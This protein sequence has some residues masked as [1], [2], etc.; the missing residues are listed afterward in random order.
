M[1][2]L[3]QDSL[4]T[5]A[6]RWS[7]RRAALL[8]RHP[9]LPF[10]L[11]FVVYM[12]VGSLEMGQPTR[13]HPKT[14]NFLGIRHEHYPIVYTT[15]IVLTIAAMAFVWP[16]GTRQTAPPGAGAL[17]FPFRVSPLAIVVG[18][19]GVVLWVW[20]CS[21]QLERKLLEPIGL[22]KLLGLGDRPAYNPL[23]QLAD[24]PTWAY[25]FLAIRFLGLAL[26]VPIIEE[27]FLR[28]FLMRFVIAEQ[29]WK[30]PFGHITPQAAV[31]GTVF[32][33]LMHPGELLAAGVW[34]SLVT[35]LMVR[36]KNI[37]DCVAAHAVTNLLLGIYVVTYGQWQLW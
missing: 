33:M 12:V 36:T 14:T 21:W 18:V 5:S 32:P 30:W 15:K 16:A 7:E 4:G 22:A 37:W 27:F 17:R 28:G 23:E 31:L 10:V 25:T 35:L 6:G 20:I 29:W 34:F 19:M 24:S 9:W 2:G 26:V 8:A 13:A 1:P 3:N 11:P